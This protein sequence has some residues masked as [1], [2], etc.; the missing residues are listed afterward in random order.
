M[1]DYSTISLG[2]A[3]RE[4]LATSTTAMPIG[5]LIAWTALALSA[6]F[7]GDQLP[8]FAP[9]VAAAIPVP[10]AI[11]IDKM[12]GEFE[13]WK[14]GNKNPVAQLFMRFITVVGLLIPLVI[15]AA[16]AT[17]ELDKASVRGDAVT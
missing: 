12:R 11:V 16:Q 1:K 7:L 14:Q 15:I 4:Y 17:G 9:F 10:I 6:F 5:G 13:I 8:T 2:D 3:R